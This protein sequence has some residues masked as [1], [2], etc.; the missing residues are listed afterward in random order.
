MTEFNMRSPYSLNSVQSMLVGDLLKD[1]VGL[2]DDKHGHDTPQRFVA[3]LDELTQCRPETRITFPVTAGEI[4]AQHIDGCIKWKAFDA[5]SDE[6]IIVEKIPFVSVCN[7][8]V[9]PF[10]GYAHIAYVPQDSMAGLS[11]FSRVVKHFAR[12]LQVQERL[13][14]D[15]TDFLEEKL[16]P[17]GIGV[18]MRA[19]HMC[20]TIRGVHSPG[21]MTTTNAMRGVFNDHT[22]T[23][24]AEF[25]QMI[26][27]S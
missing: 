21:T 8:H 9:L 10:V 1:Y 12:Q 22:R 5:E 14:A 7:H 27:G 11:K 3:M 6:M 20:M 2:R 17:R 18:V 26:R 15:V 25:L 23:A 4:N 19:E 13:T 16:A 24:K